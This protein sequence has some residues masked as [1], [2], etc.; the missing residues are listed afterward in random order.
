M[1]FLRITSLIEAALRQD[2][3]ELDSQA[4][5]QARSRVLEL[6]LASGRQDMYLLF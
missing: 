2:I 6:P 3:L 1:P 4:C 5:L